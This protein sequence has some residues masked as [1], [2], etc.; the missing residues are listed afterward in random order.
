ML[1]HFK[2]KILR[3]TERRLQHLATPQHMLSHTWATSDL[4][5]NGEWV[6]INTHG[7]HAGKRT[8]S[9]AIE[10]DLGEQCCENNV[11]KPPRCLTLG[12]QEKGMRKRQ[13]G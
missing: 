5:T 11:P 10:R 1:G 8:E 2:E 9:S 3:N 7:A 12:R 6:S 13:N 4:S